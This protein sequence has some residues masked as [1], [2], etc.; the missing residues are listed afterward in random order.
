MADIEHDA[1]RL[2]LGVGADGENLVACPVDPAGQ[3]IAGRAEP[4][5]L[6]G[7]G[8]GSAAVDRLDLQRIAV[9]LGRLEPAAGVAAHVG[10]LVHRV[11]E[12]H[13]LRP[14]NEG[15]SS[16]AE[17]EE[18][19]EVERAHRVGESGAEPAEGP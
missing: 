13:G 6:E 4:R 8:R 18:S 1:R 9:R 7:L 14:P 17:V 5:A 3:G 10:D 19:E 11:L 16:Y 12:G 2:P 15:V